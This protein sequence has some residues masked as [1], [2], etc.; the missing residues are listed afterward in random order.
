LL[1]EAI[2]HAKA[3][4]LRCFEVGYFYAPPGPSE[5]EYNIGKYKSQFGVDALVPWEGQKVFKPARF[6]ALSLLRQS[7]HRLGE[8]LKR[9]NRARDPEKHSEKDPE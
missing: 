8:L 2:L 4:G 9:K 6:L 7:K 5:K 1:W 3:R